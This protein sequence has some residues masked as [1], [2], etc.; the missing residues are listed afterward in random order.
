LVSRG[1]LPIASRWLRGRGDR[2]LAGTIAPTAVGGAQCAYPL[3]PATYRLCAR[4]RHGWAARPLWQSPAGPAAPAGV[5]VP[6]AIFFRFS[7]SPLPAGRGTAR[8][9]GTGRSSPCSWP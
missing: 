4:R 9:N 2:R 6:A 3:L 8:A 5:A 7:A 1:H